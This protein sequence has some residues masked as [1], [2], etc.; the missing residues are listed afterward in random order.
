MDNMTMTEIYHQVSIKINNY[1]YIKNSL[2]C[3]NLEMYQPVR[4]SKSSFDA[5]FYRGRCPERF[6]QVGDECLYFAT[7]GKRY[8][9]HQAQ[10]VCARQVARSLERQTS[11]VVGQPNVKP[12]KGVR[13]FILNTP[14]KTKILEALYRE[15]DELN[16]AVRLPSDFNTLNRCRN[17]KENNWPQYCT[18]PAGPNVTCF[19]TSELGSNNICLRQIDCTK[20]YSRLACEFT[21]PGLSLDRNNRCI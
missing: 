9:W 18:N 12:T 7:D 13:Q 17:G 6:Y 19:E 8:S 3:L 14:E 16:I 5:Q 4:S 2:F 21:L 1:K 11:F 10:R 15:Y 20:R